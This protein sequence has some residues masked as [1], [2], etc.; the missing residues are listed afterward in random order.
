[1]KKLAGVEKYLENEKASSRANNWY[2]LR[3]SAL[4]P[5]STSVY[6]R[7]G[8][9]MMGPYWIANDIVLFPDLTP[10]LSDMSWFDV[11]VYNMQE[12]PGKFANANWYMPV[13]LMYN[14]N[15]FEY[16]QGDVYE[17]PLKAY[18]GGTGSPEFE[19]AIE[20]EQELDSW[21]DGSLQINLSGD[22]PL[23][24]VVLRNNGTTG[25]YG[26]IQAVD[27]VN[28]GRSYLWKDL[29]QRN[30]TDYYDGYY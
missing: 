14:Y 25:V 20:A 4:T 5:P 8:W 26:A 9:V 15:Y 2:Q 6:I 21:F 27:A 23:W 30:V 24:G 10:D 19:T 18:M 1:M 22:M 12:R 16:L 28:R 3:V 13:L 29:R 17:P 7:G 11:D